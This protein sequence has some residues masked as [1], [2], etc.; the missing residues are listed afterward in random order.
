VAIEFPISLVAQVT[1]ALTPVG[2]PMADP[3][4]AAQFR[5]AL[6]SP[7]P[8]GGVEASGTAVAPDSIELSAARGAPEPAAAPSGSA[9]LGDAILQGM[10]HL[11]HHMKEGWASV[12]APVDP[13]SGPMSVEGLLHLQ[14]GVFQMGFETQ[15]IGTIAGKTSQSVD[16]L[17]KMQ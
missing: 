4:Q 10:D 13:Q 6:N 8:A 2:P 7:A 12:M 3:A 15:M 11:R 9:S 5:A 16:Q 17:V 14:T 1:K